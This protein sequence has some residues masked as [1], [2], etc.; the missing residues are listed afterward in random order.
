MWSCFRCSRE[1]LAFFKGLKDIGVLQ[2]VREVGRA[3]VCLH[4][5]TCYVIELFLVSHWGKDEVYELTVPKE[6][7]Q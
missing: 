4:S 1:G 3:V 5:Y 7:I 2:S 6:Y